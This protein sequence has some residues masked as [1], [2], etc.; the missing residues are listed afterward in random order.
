MEDPIHAMNTGLPA[1]ADI[2][3]NCRLYGY[4]NA[5]PEHIDK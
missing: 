2:F 1:K 5:G 3:F 4:K